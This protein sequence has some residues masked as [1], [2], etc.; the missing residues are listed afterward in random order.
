[1]LPDYL[2]CRCQDHHTVCPL[3]EFDHHTVERALDREIAKTLARKKTSNFAKVVDKWV[4]EAAEL[5]AKLN[6]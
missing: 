4:A 6:A 2:R 1:M 5:N 3:H